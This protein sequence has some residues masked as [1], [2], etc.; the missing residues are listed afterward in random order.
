MYSTLDN[1]ASLHTASIRRRNDA[2]LVS[3]GGFQFSNEFFLR[4][5]DPHHVG[6]LLH[7]RHLLLHTTASQ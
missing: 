1:Q 4:R 6:V 2:S 5:P 7:L 3:I